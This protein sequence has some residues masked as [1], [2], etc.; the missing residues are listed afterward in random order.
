MHQGKIVMEGA[1][2]E[3]LSNENRLEEYALKLPR[4][5]RVCHALQKGGIPLED[6]M[7]AYMVAQNIAKALPNANV[8][9]AIFE[10]EKEDRKDV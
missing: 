3:V 5:L 8:E 7:N 2:A 9:Q 6:G 10:K 4:S 1:P